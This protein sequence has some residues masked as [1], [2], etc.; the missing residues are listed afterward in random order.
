MTNLRLYDYPST[1][2]SNL[3]SF[4]VT[5][6]TSKYNAHEYHSPFKKAQTLHYLTNQ[7]GAI[8][9]SISKICKYLLNTIQI[10]YRNE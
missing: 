2:I 1:T 3:L 8:H 5:L 6:L 10:L 7:L 9:R 4:V